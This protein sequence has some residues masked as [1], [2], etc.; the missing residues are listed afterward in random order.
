MNVAVHMKEAIG[1]KDM[2]EPGGVLKDM[3][4]GGGDH[5]REIQGLIEMHGETLV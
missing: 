2:K 4:E 1:L 5:M 3:K